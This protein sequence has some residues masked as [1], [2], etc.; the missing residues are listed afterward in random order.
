ML[1]PHEPLS[2]RAL[3][4]AT[5]RLEDFADARLFERVKIT[6]DS[7][8]RSMLGEGDERPQE[9]KRA[10]RRGASRLYANESVDADRLA[11]RAQER[12]IEAIRSLPRVLVAHDTSEFDK[13]GRHEPTDAGP[14]RSSEARGYLVHYGVFVDPQSEA[15]VGIA[16]MG[17]WTRPFP[18]GKPRPEGKVAVRREWKNED[19]KWGWGVEQVCKAF[20]RYGLKAHV[21]HLADHEGSSYASLV[22]AKRRKN[23]YVTRTKVDR[24][25]REGS[26]LLFEH[27][28]KQK[29][30]DRWAVEVEEDSTGV[31]RGLAR[32]RRTAEVELRF[33]P[34]TLK[35]T[36]NYTG[37]SNRNGLRV[38]AVSVYE[39]NPPEG[40][41][42]LE[43]MLL[44]V[45]P[46]ATKADA[47]EVVQDYARRWG[48]E[49]INKVF[50]SGCQAE[51]T[52][53]PDLA[54]F[55][56]LLAVAWPIAT[57][58][59]RWTYAARVRP[60]ELAAPHVGD[61]VI[62]V[63]KLACRY[64]HLPLPRRA[65]TLSDLILRLARMGGYE[66]RKDQP[67]GWKV[68]W[69]GWRALNNFW[70]HLRFLQDY[71][72]DTPSR[73]RRGTGSARPAVR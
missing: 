24:A 9:V 6:A 42:R 34:V 52:V 40:S 45:Q 22:R 21:R 31:T 19:D 69:R 11:R 41:E 30:V 20:R 54:A 51:L 38:G 4:E 1:L 59:A 18:Q 67:P 2:G 62:E 58:I 48:I 72:A 47:K 46:I 32:R 36:S 35:V 73:N 49:D 70:D 27:L 71:E 25:I 14:L 63:L 39:P 3:T 16:Y 10:E 61:E 7:L 26:G 68:I 13:H 60:L 64:H 33:A 43:W 65:W 12:A 44:S 55:Q 23:D 53:V 50:K 15:R 28:L 57:H 66:P 37:R 8:L 56:R 29:V 5:F 17:S